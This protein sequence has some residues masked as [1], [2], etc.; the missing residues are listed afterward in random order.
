[1]PKQDRL[2]GSGSIDPDGIGVSR[3][4]DGDEHCARLLDNTAVGGVDT[5]SPGGYKH[6]LPMY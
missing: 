2:D 5:R 4:A 3:Q 6:S 1:M